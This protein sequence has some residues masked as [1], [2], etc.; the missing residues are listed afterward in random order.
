MSVY[1]NGIL[2]LACDLYKIRHCL[3]LKHNLFRQTSPSQNNPNWSTQ[4]KYVVVTLDHPGNSG[5][6]VPVQCSKGS[7]LEQQNLIACLSVC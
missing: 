4:R 7:E 2:P 6:S 3:G 1:H 5:V